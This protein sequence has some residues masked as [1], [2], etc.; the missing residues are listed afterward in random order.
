[1]PKEDR[2]PVTHITITGEI[3]FILNA[4]LHAVLQGI[5]LSGATV[6][7]NTGNLEK[8]KRKRHEIDLELARQKSWQG[9]HEPEK[10]E[11][12]IKIPADFVPEEIDLIEFHAAVI[13][14]LE[15]T[16]NSELAI[17]QNATRLVKRLRAGG[18]VTHKEDREV[19]TKEDVADLIRV[20]TEMGYPIKG[21]A[22]KLTYV[23][24]TAIF[25]LQEEEE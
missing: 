2:E 15:Q 25:S 5:E 14:I 11:W 1:M 17:R 4:A 13:A 18:F 7:V 8:P 20:Y 24:L 19:I 22:E 23:A 3:N 16:G 21:I 12:R 9:V 6:K 10:P